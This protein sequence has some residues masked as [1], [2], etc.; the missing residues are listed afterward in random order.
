VAAARHG[1][2]RMKKLW[3]PTLAI[4]A[5]VLS[6]AAVAWATAPAKN[7]TYSGTSSERSPISFKVASNGKHVTSFATT[8]GYNGKCG[9][10]GGAPFVV[11][12]ASISISKG[13]FHK[14][15]TA[16]GPRGSGIPP[17]KFD[18]SGKFSGKGGKTAKGSVAAVNLHCL[19]PNARKNPYSETYGATDR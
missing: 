5:A 3:V 19:P 10:G 18:V 7:K 9:A 14:R 15:V 11:K 12:A 13:S 2:K 8:I 17:R 16:H 1:R 4:P 6:T